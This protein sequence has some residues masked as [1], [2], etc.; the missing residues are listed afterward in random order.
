[1]VKGK[2]YRVNHN[3]QNFRY[4]ADELDVGNNILVKGSM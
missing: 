1:V 2:G 4:T 3:L